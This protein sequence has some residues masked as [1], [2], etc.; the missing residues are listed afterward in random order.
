MKVKMSRARQA[1]LPP[2]IVG[3]DIISLIAEYLQLRLEAANL[4]QRE[5]VE[6]A[7]EVLSLAF[8]ASQGALIDRARVCQAA[9]NAVRDVFEMH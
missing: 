3:D 6:L 7:R 2:S 8:A 1:G 5:A 9:A 4:S